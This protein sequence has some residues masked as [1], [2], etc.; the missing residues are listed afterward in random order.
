VKFDRESLKISMEQEQP[1][2]KKAKG[3]QKG[4]ANKRMAMAKPVAASA[5]GCSPN[6]PDR[7]FPVHD[8]PSHEIVCKCVNSNW[9]CKQVPTGGDWSP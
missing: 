1:M 5:G 8:D 3:V 9:R 6:S 2:A 4:K 7:R